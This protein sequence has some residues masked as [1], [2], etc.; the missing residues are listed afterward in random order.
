MYGILIP[1]LSPVLARVSGSTTFLRSGTASVARRTAPA[2]A[3]SSP[4]TCCRP[5]LTKKTGMPVSWHIGSVHLPASRTFSIM[6]PSSRRAIVSVSDARAVSSAATTS[7]GSTVTARRISSTVASS[8]IFSIAS[9]DG[10]LP[11]N[12]L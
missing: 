10:T 9:I 7:G 4:A 5:I 12:G 8:M 3:S 11:H 1:V 6:M 2:S